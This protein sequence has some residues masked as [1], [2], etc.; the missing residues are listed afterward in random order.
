MAEQPTAA[1]IREGFDYSSADF[2][3]TPFGTKGAFTQRGSQIQCHF[4]GEFFEHLG[5]HI[6]KHGMKKK[7]YC[8]E[9]GLVPSNTAL[10]NDRLRRLFSVINGDRLP[11]VRPAAPGSHSDCYNSI[12][13]DGTFRDEVVRLASKGLSYRAIAQRLGCSSTP[14]SRVLPPSKRAYP[15]CKLSPTDVQQIRRLIDAGLH[16]LRSIAQ[17]F[18]VHEKTIRAIRNGE[19]HN[20]GR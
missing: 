11:K 12:T 14:I 16:S 17:L 19:S 3:I 1:D 2:R 9:F 6:R 4:C 18:H 7:E 8:K 20:E 13:E 10:M 15:N 5:A